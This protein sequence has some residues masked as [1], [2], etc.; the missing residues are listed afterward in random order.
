[1][2]PGYHRLERDDGPAVTLIVSPGRCPLP[3]ELTWGFAAQLYATRSKRSWG[4]GD[5]DDLGRLGRWSGSLGA[6]FV[7]VN[8]LHAATPTVPQQPSPYFPGSRCFLNPLYLAVE[9]IPGAGG[10]T[11]V[12]ELAG[13]GRALNDARLIHRDRV[14]ALKSSALEALFEDFSGDPDFDAYVAGR[15]PLLRGFATFC[16]LSELHGG[17]W[18]SWPTSVRDPEVGGGAGVHASPPAA[19]RGCGITP[20][21]SGCWTGNSPPRPDLFLLCPTWRW[22]SIPVAPMRGSGRTY[23]PCKCGSGRRRIASTPAV[24]TGPCLPS[25]R[26]GPEPLGT[27]RGSS[28]LRGALRHGAGLRLDH[29]M[30]LFRLY[31][32]PVGAT[33][34]DGGY[35][36]YPH[37][38]LLDI[39]ALEA[40]RAGA[41]VVGED[42]G[43]VEPGVRQQLAGRN[44]L[45]Y[46]VWWFQDAAPAAWPAKALAAVSTHDLPTVAGVFTGLDLE[47]QRRLGLEPNE[48]A[49]ARLRDKLLVRTGSTA[50]TPVEEVVARVYDDL[51]AVP[52]LLLTAS[53]DD[54][55]AV[56]RAPQHARYRR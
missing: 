4:F 38:E 52:C 20:G 33:P 32:I 9:A 31:W 5:F 40:H 7:L 10:R 51:A 48:E 30:G 55:L 1:M 37:D 17:T 50:T 6:G 15:G 25:T 41:F 18:Q 39:V 42:L 24:R 27:S 11:D 12:D 14:W 29:V 34:P 45:S 2:P 36:R 44:L 35:V 22:A 23:S 46:Q 43:T 8:P 26:G 13:A 28:R 21:C 47:A 16:A 19:R 49:S 3:A 53:L 56:D 54:A